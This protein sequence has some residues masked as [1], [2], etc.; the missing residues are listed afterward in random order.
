MIMAILAANTAWAKDAAICPA[1]GYSIHIVA[2]HRH[3]DGTVHGPYQ[4]AISH[5]P[6][7]KLSLLDYTSRI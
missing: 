3:E 6:V 1:A 7:A 5:E 2:P 4:T